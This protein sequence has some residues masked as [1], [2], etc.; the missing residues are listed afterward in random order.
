[1]N[2]DILFY[3]LVNGA[4]RRMHLAKIIALVATNPGQ[5]LLSDTVKVGEVVRYMNDNERAS[6]PQN[7][8][9]IRVI[10]DNDHPELS[11]GELFLGNFYADEPDDYEMVTWQTKRAGKQAYSVDQKPLPPYYYP[12]FVWREEIFPGSTVPKKVAVV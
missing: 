10:S 6:L 4:C 2:E 8:A 12:V 5:L 7:P 11:P 1:M 9:L 3:V